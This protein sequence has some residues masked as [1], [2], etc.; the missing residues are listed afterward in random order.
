M[1][2]GTSPGCPVNESH[3]ALT[4]YTVIFGGPDHVIECDTG[5]ALARAAGREMPRKPFRE[6]F[7]D[8]AGQI[9]A[10]TLDRVYRT[11]EPCQ[12]PECALCR[13]GSGQSFL[14]VVLAPR[15]D[16]AGV[17]NGVYVFGIN[18]T[19]AVLAVRAH[20]QLAAEHRQTEEQLL[21]ANERLRAI[22]NASPLAIITLARDGAIRTWN[23]AAERI[24]GWSAE[25][26]MSCTGPYLAAPAFTAFRALL[27]QVFTEGT[28]ATTELDCPGKDGPEISISVSMAPVWSGTG[29]VVEAIAVAEDVT[30]RKQADRLLRER[31][32]LESIGMLAGGLAHDFNNLLTA[33]MGGADLALA[34]VSRRHP[35]REYLASVVAAS[36]RA[37][38]LTRQLLAY[39]GRGRAVIERVDISEVVM[40]AARLTQSSIPA[41]IEVRLRMAPAL[42]PVEADRTQIEQLAFNL[43][44][45]AAEAIGAGAGEIT[46]ATGLER[47]DGLPAELAFDSSTTF[48]AGAYVYVD[49]R[50][51]GCGVDAQT[52]ARLFDPFFS[53]KAVGRGLGLPA[54]QGIVRGHKGL[55]TLSSTPGSGTAFRVLLPA[56]ADAAADTASGQR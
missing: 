10:D 25:E 19:E 30:S 2:M 15:R 42:P 53:T 22:I 55:A 51:T 3:N 48:R 9:F 40:D 23:S 43:I 52:R 50:D 26:V 31:Q 8:E 56:A 12:C 28:C 45:N 29:A 17:I 47:L 46:I 11:G 38:D 39:S 5:G 4:V 21:S 14:S 27:D 34:A 18:I 54:V 35:A 37:A 16:S 1:D 24:F 41:P 32:R 6:V 13:C 7:P 36:K 49:V 20:E 33:I 44:L